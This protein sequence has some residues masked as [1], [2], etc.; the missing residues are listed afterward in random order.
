MNEVISLAPKVRYNPIRVVADQTYSD[1][2]NDVMVSMDAF[3]QTRMISYLV[4]AQSA[5]NALT[6]R[7]QAGL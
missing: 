1:L 3:R 4:Q 2:M 7:A 5:I 6:E